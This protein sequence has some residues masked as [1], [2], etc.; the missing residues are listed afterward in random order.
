MK[1]G[2][3]PQPGSVRSRK[4]AAN[5]DRS[6]IG[7][8]STPPRAPKYLTKTARAIWR[9]TV[10]RL[11]ALQ[12]LDSADHNLVA[13][14]AEAVARH[15]AASEELAGSAVT[16]VSDRGGQSVH[17]AARVQQQASESIR[18]LSI[19]LG[20]TLSGRMKLGKAES[21]HENSSLEV[22]RDEPRRWRWFDRFP[23]LRDH[24]GWVSKLSCEDF[25]SWAADQE[26]KHAET[27]PT[28]RAHEI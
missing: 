11:A 7:P 22:F 2:P 21:T 6:T 8:P 18:K 23:D 13:A 5:R 3:P 15:R 17:P 24:L 25:D 10:N 12:L 4:R 9:E 14:Y 16:G 26:R 20:L 27:Q 19:E 1:S 28:Q